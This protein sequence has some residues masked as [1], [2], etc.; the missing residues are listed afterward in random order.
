[1]LCLD[2]VLPFCF[3]CTFLLTQLP[4]SSPLC[5]KVIAATV[6]GDPEKFN[7]VFLGKPNE[8]YCAWILDPEKWG[9]EFQHYRPVHQL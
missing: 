3:L 8:A 2:L 1:L 9:G 6:A 7:E 4:F 5:S